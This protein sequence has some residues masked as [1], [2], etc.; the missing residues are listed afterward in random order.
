MDSLMVRQAYRRSYPKPVLPQYTGERLQ[1]AIPAPEVTKT[2]L[3]L[4]HL[5][6]TSVPCELDESEITK[7]HSSVITAKVIQAAK[8]AGGSQYKACVVWRPLQA[9]FH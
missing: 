7:A 8:E 6:E 3:K 4:R 9:S 5:I 1:S 2:A